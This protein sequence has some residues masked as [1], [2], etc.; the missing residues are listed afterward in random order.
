MTITTFKKGD[1]LPEYTATL[2]TG[3]GSAAAAIDL[4]DCTVLFLMTTDTTGTPKVNAAAT[5]VGTATEG[6]VKYSWD[7]DDL[8]TAG[9]FLVEWEITYASGKKLTVPSAGY[10]TV[11]VLDDIA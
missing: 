1:R 11:R 8:D 4:T 7:T 6:N 5:I 2:Q 9:D 10:D 3:S